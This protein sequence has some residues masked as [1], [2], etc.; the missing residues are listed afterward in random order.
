MGGSTQTRLESPRAR[1]K[2]HLECAWVTVR[3]AHDSNTIR[4][5]QHSPLAACNRPRRRSRRDDLAPDA[6]AADGAA[7]GPAA[8]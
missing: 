4:W 2:L 8:P 7:L 1:L 5:G 6:Q 3:I